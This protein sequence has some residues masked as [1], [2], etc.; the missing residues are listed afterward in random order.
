MVLPLVQVHR[1]WHAVRPN[2]SPE[3]TRAGMAFTESRT[4]AHAPAEPVDAATSF[5]A[6]QFV[7]ERRECEAY[8]RDVAALLPAAVETI[9]RAGGF[10][11]PV[12]F[13]HVRLI[14][15]GFTQRGTA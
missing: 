7:L 9:I 13:F 4:I 6:S 12:R 8:E 10:D 14:H 11:T 2:P 1:S 5:L 15:G 3:P